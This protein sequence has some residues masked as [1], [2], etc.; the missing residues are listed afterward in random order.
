MIEK[1]SKLIYRLYNRKR[2]A[3]ELEVIISTLDKKA[4]K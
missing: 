1:Q 4:R 2:E 3:K